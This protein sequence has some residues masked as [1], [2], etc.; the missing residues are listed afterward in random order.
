M[1]RI[2]I[3]E[4]FRTSFK[5]LKKRHKSLQTDFERL[6][7]SLLDNPM[8]GVELEGGARKIRLAI[9]S[10]GRGKSGGARVIIRVRIIEGELHLLYIYDKSDFDNVSD[11]FLRDIMK[12][13]DY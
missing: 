2:K 7:A 6:L 11:S 9:T 12:R 5:R 13:M 1:M 4:E 3:S 10:K 8:Q